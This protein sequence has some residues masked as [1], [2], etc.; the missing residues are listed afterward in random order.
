MKIPYL[1][2]RNNCLLYYE[3]ADI[4]VPRKHTPIVKKAYSGKVTEGVRKRIQKAIDILVQKSPVRMTYNPITFKTFPFRLNFITLTFSTPELIS[5]DDAYKNMIKPLLR[6]LR[7]GNDFSYVWKAEFQSDKDFSGKIKA[8]GGQL[9]Y[10]IASNK[11]IPYTSIRLEWNKLQRKQGYLKAY[12]LKHRHY[13]P[14]SIDIHSVYHVQDL[15]S[16]LGKY[17]SKDQSKIVKGKVWDCSKDCKLGRFSFILCNDVEMKIRKGRKEGKVTQI[18]L[19]H[20]TIFKMKDPLSYLSSTVFKEYV[21]WRD[22]I[23][24]VIKPVIKKNELKITLSEQ[25]EIKVKELKVLTRHLRECHMEES[26]YTQEGQYDKA[27]EAGN[28]GLKIEGKRNS[29]IDDLKILRQE[30]RRSQNGKTHQIALF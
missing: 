23:V 16:Y 11:F 9:H 14:N 1:Q 29:V 17:M 24:K 22:N 25:I 7:K 2:V 4:Q 15:S 18:D 20:C 10:H 21:S 8:N 19:E 6:K 12:G 26:I 27:T 3:M 28:E 13:D 5:A 30:K